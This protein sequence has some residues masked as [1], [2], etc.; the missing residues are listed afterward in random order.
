MH[1]VSGLDEPVGH[2]LPRPGAEPGAGYEY[3]CRH[4]ATVRRRSDNRSTASERLQPNHDRAADLVGEDLP[5]AVPDG[6]E[7]AER[8]QATKVIENVADLADER[9]PRTD[10]LRVVFADQLRVGD[11][12]APTLSGAAHAEP[13]VV[14]PQRE[15][16]DIEDHADRDSP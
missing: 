4:W 11:L 7:I 15:R 10:R 9:T 12:L 8:E 14:R 2:V 1:L 5:L 3:E 16:D 13:S 6:P